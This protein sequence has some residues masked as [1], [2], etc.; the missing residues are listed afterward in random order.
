[1]PEPCHRCA[2][3]L[4]VYTAH[5]FDLMAQKV[6]LFHAVL[7]HADMSSIDAAVQGYRPSM[8]Q[9]SAHKRTH[10]LQRSQQR[11]PP[12]TPGQAPATPHTSWTSPTPLAGIR[13][14]VLWRGQLSHVLVQQTPAKRMPRSRPWRLPKAACT[15]ALCGCL[16]QRWGHPA[17]L[18]VYAW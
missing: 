5:V 14:R 7:P 2:V 13:P 4:A 1:M 9:P 11:A 15:A 16:P 10:R 6:L 17:T 3:H 8:R 18:Q 12:A